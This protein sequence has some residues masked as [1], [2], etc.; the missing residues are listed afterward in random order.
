MHRQWRGEPETRLVHVGFGGGAAQF[1]GRTIYA[2]GGNNVWSGAGAAVTGGSPDFPDNRDGVHPLGETR[3]I[4]DRLRL[5]SVAQ[6][7]QT[8]VGGLTRRS[9]PRASAPP[10]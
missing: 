1:G 10:I 9:K 8:S 6:Q 5:G 7:L 2:G 3:K 4:R